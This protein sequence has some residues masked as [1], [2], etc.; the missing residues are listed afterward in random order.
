MRT[1]AAL[2]ALA[3]AA[4]ACSAVED[5]AVSD[6]VDPVYLAAAEQLCP[7]MWEWQKNVGA[8]MNA[9][10]YEARQ[11]EDA[12]ERRSLYLRAF[13]RIRELNAQL[14]A[15]VVSLGDEDPLS[16]I[17]P[18]VRAGLEQSNSILEMSVA[19]VDLA[20]SEFDAPGYSDI[21][22][23][24][25]LDVEKVIDVAKPE[26][27]TYEDQDLI[28]AFIAVPQCQ[29]GVKDANDGVVRYVP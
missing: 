12:L 20:Y 1:A 22:P 2:V 19:H 14:D 25:F 10:S 8:T 15:T 26:M 13:N 17:T 3:L 28:D 23:T 18:D 9:M 16:R 11:E 6:P 7:I 27:A 21:V 5:E 4:S 29:H 24:I